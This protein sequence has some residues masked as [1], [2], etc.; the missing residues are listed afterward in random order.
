M[1][2]A[3]A[4]TAPVGQQAPPARAAAWKSRPLRGPRGS[5]LLTTGTVP[6]RSGSSDRVLRQLP[7]SWQQGYDA[8]Y[9]GESGCPFAFGS[10][11]AWSWSSGYV[12][13]KA[14]RLAKAKSSP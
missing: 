12:E 3:P 14:A 1:T 4:T 7:H 6:N 11:E 8:G 13:G 10:N 9:L 5:L 2:A